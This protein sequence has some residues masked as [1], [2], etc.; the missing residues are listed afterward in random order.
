MEDKSDIPKEHECS[1]RKEAKNII[2]RGEK[3]T[4]SQPKLKPTRLM[5]RKP[6]FRPLDQEHE[7]KSPNKSTIQYCKSM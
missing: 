3:K 6:D 1:P 5:I 4:W 7:R 2:A